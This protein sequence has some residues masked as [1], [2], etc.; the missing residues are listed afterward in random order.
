[1]P[2]D[3]E[4]L[5]ALIVRTP[6]RAFDS[7][8]D[9]ATLRQQVQDAAFAEAL[10]LASP[11][12]H[13][14]SRKLLDQPADADP[15]KTARLFSSL[16]RYY[17]R[18][19]SRP[20]PFALFAGCG[21]VRWG[22]QSR[23]PRRPA[24][25]RRHTRL[26]MHYLCALARHLAAHPALR[27]QLRYTPNSSLYRI[28]EEF[29][30][31]E[32][33][34]D[35]DGNGHQISSVAA[36]EALVQALEQ[37]S[38]GATRAALAAGL[39]SYDDADPAEVLAFVDELI[40]AQLLVSELEPA[41][42][43]PEFMDHVLAVLTRLQAQGAG[44]EVAAIGQTLRRVGEALAELD[45]PGAD[46]TPADYEHV[47]ELLRPLGV[48]LEANKLFQTDLSFRAEDAMLS[49]ELQAPLLE[50]LQVL[51]YLARPARN[52]RLE[53]FR[54]QFQ[55]RYEEQEVPLLE[56]LDNESGLGYADYGKNSYSAL[57]HGLTWTAP[58]SDRRSISQDE[59][60]RY[61]YEKLRAADRNGDYGIELSLEE[62]RG[63]RPVAGPLPP[64][65]AV[66]FRVVG[67][68]Q[69]LLDSVG[70]SSAAN[71]LGR[72]A[73]AEPAI[74]Q[75]LDELTALEQARNPGVRLAEICHLPAGRIGNILQRPSLRALEIPYLAQSLL[76]AGQQVPPQDLYLS[77][78]QG[79]LVLRSRRLNAVIVPRLS[80]A[81]NYTAQA[82]P[83]YQ[84][85]CDL[86]TQ[87]QQ[88]QL[89]FSWDAISFYTKFLPRL[90]TGRVVLQPASWQ[91]AAEDFQP[92]LTADD[93]PAAFRAFRTHWRLPARFTLADGDNELLVDADNLFTVRIWLD[94]IR[95][96]PSIKLKEF[97][98]DPEHS[99]VTDAAGRGYVNQFVAALLR[100]EPAHPLAPVPARVPAAVQR[101]FTLGSEWLYAKLYC[102]PKVA[103]RVLAEAVKPL[104]DALLAD[105]L[106]DRWFF[107]RYADPDAHLRLRLHLPDTGRIGAVV[108]RL[109]EALA[110]L[111][112]ARYV[113]KTQTDTYRRELERYGAPTIG[114][115]E[116]L[117]CADSAAAAQLIE[118]YQA[119]PAP[120]GDVYWL[121]G[122][123]FIDDLLDA[124]AYDTARKHQLL[125][126]LRDAFA[127]EFGADKALRLQLDHKYREH[128]RAIEQVLQPGPAADLGLPVALPRYH[129]E[130]QVQAV[131]QELLRRQAEG[132]LV[133][134]LDQ[135][136][137]SYVHMLL[138]RLMAVQPRLH[139][140][141]IYDFLARYY[142]AR[143]ARARKQ[144]LTS[145][146]P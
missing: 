34:P 18:M 80:S 120:D 79:Q 91:L 9:E 45:R 64:S 21:V 62:L 111:V 50:A 17:G 63:F 10:L 28:G 114:L 76:P 102:G 53:Q 73:H 118:Q 24:D 99:P 124:V 140:L 128:R 54:Q 16:G 58:A 98:F 11:D 68:G 38:D 110:P 40:E 67:A 2:H 136:L 86:Q 57:I 97:L 41:V 109:G 126:R 39:T 66:L 4:F 121:S 135:L 15:R 19:S 22:A 33:H 137:G 141:V 96:R 77:V 75:V 95:N 12:L 92:L 78:R 82:L 55:A 130:P 71:L 119:L 42:T 51:T 113:W 116:A 48:P 61:L 25:A 8:Y 37:A 88:A 139:E 108:Q 36:S 14:E 7:T 27:E 94:T 142:Q 129:R 56:A 26:D 144:E 100:R 30:Y 127:L 112:Q 32:S 70:G 44:P 138:N 47:A 69:L 31:I 115:A 87:N 5:P 106:I 23:V 6:A 83:V 13:R 143:L 49:T 59:V 134:G 93:W 101:T 29:R 46:N 89:N 122:L 146:L 132:S 43:G 35:G 107:I 90:S 133:P 131:A 105:G 1:M 81:H 72:F 123:R 85:L 117:F 20:T 74:G 145:C 52:A 84:F 125:Q 3:Y 65:V 60:Q 104:T 103:D